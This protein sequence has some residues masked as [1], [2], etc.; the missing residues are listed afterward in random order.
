[1]LRLIVAMIAG[2][3]STLGISI[4]ICW[5]TR[6]D[7]HPM[8]DFEL[9]LQVAGAIACTLAYYAILQAL[10]RRRPRLPRAYVVR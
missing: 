4:G 9:P 10:A 3:T 2:T 1:M 5:L 8:R 7:A 6:H